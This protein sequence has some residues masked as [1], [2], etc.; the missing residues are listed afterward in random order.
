MW[1]EIVLLNMLLQTH[2]GKFFKK[3]LRYDSSNFLNWNRKVY[4]YAAIRVKIWW[5]IN[6]HALPSK[7]HLA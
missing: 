5:I 1:T 3:L 7:G 2:E 4:A 6:T